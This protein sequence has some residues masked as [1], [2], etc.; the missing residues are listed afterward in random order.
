MKV[1][2]MLASISC[3]LVLLGVGVAPAQAATTQA[4]AALQPAISKKVNAPIK[5]Q[6]AENV[7]DLG[8]YK[9]KTGQRVKKDRLLRSDSLDKLTKA[10][11]KKLA[12][13]YHVKEV[14]DLR[15]KAQIAEKPDVK[16]AGAKYLGSSILGTKSNYDNDDEGMYRDMANKPAAKKSYHKFLVAAA[17]NKKGALLFHCSHGMDRTGT[18]AA[19]LYTILGV[20]K[21]DIQRDYLLSNTQLNVTWA[22]P[23]LL[24]LFYSEVKGQYG[25]MNNYIKKGLKIT[26]AQIKQI[27]ANYLTKA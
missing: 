23:A 15:T 3:S 2:A 10:D 7:R 26:P 20:S 14:F 8:G 12:K 1:R 5:L 18:S 4:D 9:T 13:K 11:T 24:N 17:K 19:I 21:K 16:I 25:S 27:K 22:K 6:G